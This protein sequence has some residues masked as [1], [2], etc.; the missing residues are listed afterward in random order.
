MCGL[1]AG[2]AGSRAGAWPARRAPTA[3]LR[4]ACRRLAERPDNQPPVAWRAAAAPGEA[5]E[6]GDG[7][8]AD[9]GMD[10]D[11]ALLEKRHAHRTMP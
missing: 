1:G 5:G 8:L 9:G 4:A 2:W 10:A 7:V 6:E 3:A 11:C